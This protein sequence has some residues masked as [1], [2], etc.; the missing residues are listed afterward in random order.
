MKVLRINPARWDDWW[1]AYFDEAFPLIEDS[2]IQQ[3]FGTMLEGASGWPRPYV[4]EAVLSEDELQSLLQ[5]CAGTLP[6]WSREGVIPVEYGLENY[7]EKR[8]LYRDTRRRI[9][10]CDVQGRLWLLEGKIEWVGYAPCR[11]YWR[12][13]TETL[14]K[15]PESKAG[16]KVRHLVKDL[17]EGRWKPERFS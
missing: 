12:P 15:I 13:H 9:F 3:V 14:T 10:Y 5:W 17:D 8:N 4:S 7:F 2:M 1:N 16:D 11:S 6:N